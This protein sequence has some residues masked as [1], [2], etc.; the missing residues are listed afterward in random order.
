MDKAHE[1]QWLV[2]VQ[3]I[4]A[5]VAVFEKEKRVVQDYQRDYI[6]DKCL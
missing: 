5:V 1:E 4:A 2:W 3:T 6:K